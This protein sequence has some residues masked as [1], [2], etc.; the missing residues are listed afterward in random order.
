VAEQINTDKTQMVLPSIE[1]G[2]DFSKL[3]DEQLSIAEKII[4][5]AEA[6][7]L[8]PEIALSIAHIENRF[9]QGRVSPKGAI[10]VMQLMP[11]TAEML[12]V[13]PTDVDQNIK[14]GIMYYKQMLDKY[15]DPNIAAIAYNAGPGVA[16]KFLKTD[17]PSVIPTETLDYVEQLNN[18]YSPGMP[19]EA[20]VEDVEE[21]IPEVVDFDVEETPDVLGKAIGAGAGTVVGMGFGASS[22]KKIAAAEK[23]EAASRRPAEAAAKKVARIEERISIKEPEQSNRIKIQSAIS[24]DAA[25]E[26]SRLKKAA[27]AAEKRLMKATDN[28]RRF[29]V[30]EETVRTL[31]GGVTQEGGLGSG[32]MRHSNVMG[33]ITEANVVRKGTAAAGPGYSQKSR[34]IVPDKYA[35]VE[36]Y[37]PEQKTA[38][39]KYETAQKEHT[40]LIKA[41]EKAEAAAQKQ[42][43][44]LRNV[45]VRGPTGLSVAQQQLEAA[46]QSYADA[47]KGVK[48]PGRFTRVV[49]GISKIPGA[50]ALPGAFAGLDAADAAERYKQGDI[51]GAL[52]SGTG[53]LGGALSMVPPVNPLFAGARML[54]SGLSLAAPAVQYMRDNFNEDSEPVKFGM[55]GV[56]STI[57][58]N[59]MEKSAKKKAVK[60]SEALGQHEGKTLMTTQADRTKVGEGFLG[61]PG[62]SGLQLENPAYGDVGAAWAVGNSPTASTIINANRRVPPG[63]AIWT[64]MIGSPTQHKSNTMVFNRIMKDF[65]DAAKK[66]DLDPELRKAIN[67]RIAGTVDPKTGEPVFDLNKPIDILSPAFQ[68]QL[69]TFDKR[70]AVADILGGKGV[71]GKK[72]TIIDYNKII[73]DTTDPDLLEAPTG[74][75]GSRLFTLSGEKIERPDLHPSFP[76]VLTGE[77]LGVHFPAAPREI[78]LGGYLKNFRETKGR[79]PGYM[80]LTRGL[81]PSN[82]ITEE[83]LTNL[84]KAGYKKGGLAAIKHQKSVNHRR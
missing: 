67:F 52:I 66:G 27:D 30:L 18:L 17:D 48:E 36:L 82:L 5:E 56:V 57:I 64:P 54:G 80:D 21:D 83:I 6:Q 16:D 53:A 70:A 23:A 79:D 9:T 65:K 61:G 69:T 38:L 50:F 76:H 59:A 46:K 45:A 1:V 33:E 10:G 75:L 63:Q 72:G 49:R 24:E 81:A 73:Q 31:P 15:N 3:S 29:G 42:A 11:G 43:E 2:V 47:V 44:R 37:N 19:K 25:K 4:A 77:D 20:T 84:Q 22:D 68:K 28:A 39:A 7:G 60:A 62:F 58:K 78:L 13:D 32:A 41:A 71:G 51:T 34:L 55:G 12:K 40:R 74:S 8:D 26:A 35:S 14:G